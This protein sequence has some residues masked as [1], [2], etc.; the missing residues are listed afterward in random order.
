VT[1][2]QVRALARQGLWAGTTRGAAPG[3]VQCNV[4]ILPAEQADGFAAW[5]DRN[6]DVA[7]VLARSRPGDPSL[8]ELGDIDLRHDLPAYRAWERG[9]AIGEVGDIADRWS[10]DLVG[11]AFG[12]S[13][14]LEDALRRSGVSLAYERRGFGGAIY[15]TTRQTEAVGGFGAPLIV[16]MRPLR[17]DDAQRAVQVSR[18]Y[19]MLH[20]APVQVGEPAALGI[21]LDR[22]LDWI[23]TVDIA[24]DELPVFWACGVTT[25][26]ALTRARPSRAYTHV[27][28]R[29]LVTD[30]VLEDD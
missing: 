12:C 4:V 8:P 11:F 17:P 15:E 14:S 10:Q 2:A 26:A 22:P 5:C 19:P 13:F 27:S 23:G 7:P 24:S 18:R 30:L 3:Y 29:M 25:H 28:G 9:D 6:R 20:G 21:E 1:G 16:S